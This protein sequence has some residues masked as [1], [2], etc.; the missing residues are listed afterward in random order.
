MKERHINA[1]AAS[2]QLNDER[3]RKHHVRTPHAHPAVRTIQ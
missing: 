2:Q 1:A 3:T